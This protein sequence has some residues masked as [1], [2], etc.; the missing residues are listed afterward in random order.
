MAKRVLMLGTFDTKGEEH[1]FLREELM[2][3]GLEVVSMDCGIMPSDPIFPVTVSAEDV[4]QAGGSTLEALRAAHVR[5]NALDIML[6]GAI[7]ISLDLY[8]RGKIN[9]VIGMGGGGGTTLSAGVMQKL[10][11]GFPKV[12]ISTLSS[13]NTI[14]YTA[15]SDLVMFPSVTDICGINNFFRMIVNEAVGALCGMVNRPEPVFVKTDRPMVFISM[16]GNTTP[17]GNACIRMLKEHDIDTMVFH[18]TGVGG[19]AMEDMIRAGYADAVLDLTL[20]EWADQICGGIEAA[21]ENRMDAAGEIGIPQVVIPGCVD[22]VNFGPPDTVPAR[23]RDT[24]RIF[25]SWDASVT[26]MRT[27]IE[28]NA[29]IG[30]IIA[31]KI[32]RSKGPVCCLIP[33]GGLSTLDVPGGI[34]YDRQ[35]DKALF[36][37]IL[38]DTKSAI[39]VR[40]IPNPINS[41]SFAEKV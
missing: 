30:R 14:P 9:G 4:A 35:A 24:N 34:F 26:L 6:T 37:A 3:C 12:C 8:K 18:T 33:E 21:G 11:Y 36:D 7:K 16:F 25:Y 17:C 2:R 23:Y 13:G 31:G 40:K 41:E 38:N 10:P 32:N 27:N 5:G 19:R 28:E 29:Q 1:A 22:M 15:T 39:S 20:T